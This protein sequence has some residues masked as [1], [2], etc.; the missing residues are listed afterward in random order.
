[1][2]F[3]RPVRMAFEDLRQLRAQDALVDAIAV[4]RESIICGEAAA[5]AVGKTFFTSDHHFGHEKVIGYSGRPF[6]NA[7]EMDAEMMRR[8]NARVRPED[9]VYHLGDF[10]FGSQADIWHRAHLLNGHKILI[11]GNH[12]LY[13]FRRGKRPRDWEDAITFFRS[14]G[15]EEVHQRLVIK[16]PGC[17][18]L[19][20]HVP[21]DE[22]V[23]W[24]QYGADKNLCG[25]VH[26]HWAR[27]GDC[28]N[29]GVD[30]R[31]FEPKTLDEL[32]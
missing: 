21:T 30:V 28:I 27:R 5:P 3:A 13:H 9:T 23:M 26:Q 22:K 29:V 15:F 10:S 31:D 4:H 17:V 16:T 12:D 32:R 24:E 20:S 1:V 25:H 2:T 8:W 7:A 18:Y 19:L 11:M 14:I 6:A